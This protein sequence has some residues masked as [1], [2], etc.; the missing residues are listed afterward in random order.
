MPFEFQTI[1]QHFNVISH[2]NGWA[3]EITCNR[4]PF[5]G[6]TLWFQDHE[7]D[8]LREFTNQFEDESALIDRF[9]LLL[10]E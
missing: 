1:N 2:G 8:E 9:E 10:T 4:H 6:E 3:Y 7:A 5:M